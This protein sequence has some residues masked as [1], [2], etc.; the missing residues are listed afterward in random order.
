MFSCYSALMAERSNF[1]LSPASQLNLLRQQV[2][3]KL[4]DEAHCKGVLVGMA[5]LSL[6]HT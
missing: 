6:Q 4:K 3:L 1:S 5:A 2:S